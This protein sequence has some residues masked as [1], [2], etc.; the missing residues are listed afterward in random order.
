M[1]S[2]CWRYMQF[3][4]AILAASNLAFAVCPG[5][6]HE[7]TLA[8]YALS[9]DGTRIAAVGD[10]GAFF[11]WDASSGK[12]IQLLDCLKPANWQHPILF[13]PDS[14][15]VAVAVGQA[16]GVF[17]LSSGKLI[18]GLT[19]PNLKEIY[20]LAFSA[21]GQRLAASYETGVA[22]WD[23]NSRDLVASIQADPKRNALA[24]NDDGT[25]LLLGSWDGV[26]LWALGATGSTRRLVENITAES[27]LFAHHDQWIVALT[28]AALPL[29]S[30]EHFRKYQRE[31]GVWD[32]LS[33]KRLKTLAPN[34]PLD[35]LQ[36]GLSS[37][38]PDGVLAS[39]FKE[40]LYLWDLETGALKGSW[41]TLA[42]HAS[43]DGMLLLRPGGLPG[44]LELW[45]IGSPDSDV[46]RFIYK[47]PLCAS[48]LQDA[49]GN[50]R[51][52]ALAIG[53]GQ[54][55]D[56]EPFGSY[57]NAG[58][59]AHDCTPVGVSRLSYKTEERARQELQRRVGR[60]LEILDTPQQ[61]HLDDT[62]LSQ[63]VALRARGLTATVNGFSI[64]WLQG[65]SLIEI[66]STSLPA[67][68]AMEKWQ[69]Q[70]K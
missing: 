56:D 4:V 25:S 16:V 11:W 17:D 65:K 50:V 58:Y 18:A 8:G 63:R 42:G 23:L 62:A 44:E 48:S 24:L 19:A 22:V 7:T 5:S 26:E 12:R 66:Y 51:F 60:A 69:S 9:A 46:R 1:K 67:A 57:S 37:G 49:D 38:G 21:D 53:D 20:N 15:Q 2:C 39:D 3:L 41:T 14:A 29:K 10:D 34:G 45:E 43:S 40:Q 64:L 55:A 70:R 32:R 31:I 52:D 30:N 28:A 33:G 13:S 36:F 59:V 35:E 27:V 68:L 61:H 54:S 6:R 47:S